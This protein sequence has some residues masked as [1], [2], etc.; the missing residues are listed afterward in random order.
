MWPSLSRDVVLA[1]LRPGLLGQDLVS[2]VAAS[3]LV[4]LT[5]IR[6]GGPRSDAV[7]T[8]LVAYLAYAYGLVT[9][10]GVPNRLFLLHLAVF[11][12]GA[13][14]LVLAARTPWARVLPPPPRL[15]LAAA[16]GAALP[17]VVLVPLRIS[18][19]LPMIDSHRRTAGFS[20]SVLDLGFVVPAFVAAAVLL[21]LRPERGLRF[22]AV[23]FVYGGTV[24]A[25]VAAV[26]AAGPLLGIEAGP[27]RWFP[28][29]V[30]GALLLALAVM[31]LRALRATSGTDAANR[32]DLVA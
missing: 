18:A 14:T 9:L 4:G 30:L 8:G 1:A 12:L 2:A 31:T 26:A 13:W 19:L 23:V 15:R 16:V 27:G 28:T 5:L 21:L 20:V 22:S 7:A 6:R 10:E 25:S 17:A 11:A 32:V 3:V 29:L 24:M